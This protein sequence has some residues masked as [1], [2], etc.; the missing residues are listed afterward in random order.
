MIP[1]PSASETAIDGAGR[2]SARWYEFMSRLTRAVNGPLPLRALRVADLP[3]N[4]TDGWIAYCS[5]AGAGGV[6]V[7]SRGGVWRRFDTNAAVS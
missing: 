5:D 7:Y 1:L 6:P 3:S 2:M 4:P